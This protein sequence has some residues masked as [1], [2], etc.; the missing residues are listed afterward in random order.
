MEPVGSRCVECGCVIHND[1]LYQHTM[2]H[3]RLRSAVGGL[4]PV[5][6]EPPPQADREDAEPE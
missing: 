1:G 6:A 5:P 2:W 3:E 4:E